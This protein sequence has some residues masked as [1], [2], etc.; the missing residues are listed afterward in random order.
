MNN[1]AGTSP[2]WLLVFI[3]VGFA[4]LLQLIGGG[5]STTPST[6]VYSGSNTPEHRYVRER[7][8][9]EGFSGSDAE[10]AARAVMKFHDA[11]NKARSSY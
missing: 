10:A 5:A 6:P 7:F 8:K 2:M 4:M 3:V 11:Q 9:Q 1:S